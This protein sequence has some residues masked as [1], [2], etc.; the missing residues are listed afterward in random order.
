MK[1]III[2]LFSI[3]I[4]SLFIL[5]VLA[6]E[7]TTSDSNRVQNVKEKIEKTLGRKPEKVSTKVAE[8]ENQKIKNIERVRVSVKARGE[9]YS[10][11]IIRSEIL[12]DKLQIRIN[13]AKVVGKD[14]KNAE[15]AMTDAR[16]KLADAKI[17]MDEV[18]NLA[19]TAMDKQSFKDVQK[20]LQFI[21]K[22]LNIVRQ[23]A[24]KIIRS[25]KEFNSSTSSAKKNERKSATTSAERD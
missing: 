15:S 13:A 23:D 2:S 11:L 3:G 21:H 9:A 17:K 10:K 14:T 7:S 19:G 6:V 24:S 4:L 5:P 20:K 22:D 16:A 25:L 18:K 1:K 12:L 8:L